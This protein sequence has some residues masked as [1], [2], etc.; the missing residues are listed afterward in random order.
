M[1]PM[2]LAE[3]PSDP[4]GP[5]L[6]TESLFESLY[7][8]LRRLAGQVFAEQNRRHTLQP[9]ALINEVWLKLAKVDHFEDRTHFFALAAKAMR[10][11]LTDHARH[12]NREK[13]GGGGLRLTLSEHLIPGARDETDLIAFND[14]LDKLA[15]LNQRHAK[16]AEYR[17]LGSLTTE[18]IARLLDVN[19]RTVKRD[20][21]AARLWLLGELFS[22]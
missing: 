16:V 22:E 19:E 4:S 3:D 15:S 17:L 7:D 13:R 8:E 1:P 12:N 6:N 5:F 14:A 9:T 18:E 11:I 2:S 20:W 21:Q 10:Q